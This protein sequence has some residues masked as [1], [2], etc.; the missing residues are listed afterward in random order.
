MISTYYTL[1]GRKRK[2]ALCDI[3]PVPYEK[4]KKTT[5]FSSAQL[6][7]LIFICMNYTGGIRLLMEDCFALSSLRFLFLIFNGKCKSEHKSN[8]NK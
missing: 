5:K 7:S 1:V 3:H 8:E 4:W 6:N 2:M